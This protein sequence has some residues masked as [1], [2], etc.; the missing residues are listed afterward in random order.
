M[1][2]KGYATEAKRLLLDYAFGELGLHSLWAIAVEDNAASCRALEKQG[3]KKSGLLRKALLV[4]GRWVDAI[5]YDVLQEE[6]DRIRRS[7][8]QPKRGSKERPKRGSKERPK[9]RPS[10]AER[11]SRA[12]TPKPS[13]RPDP[14]KASS[15]HARST[16]T[17]GK[18]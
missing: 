3:Y 5:Y 11:P 8:E 10:R 13:S 16:R 4:K 15:R 2:N 1:R 17:A 18:S 7:E 6:W 14:S 9:S 12:G